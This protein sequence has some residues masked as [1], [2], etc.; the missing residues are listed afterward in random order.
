MSEPIAHL[1]EIPT[2][3]L[4][5]YI[6][7]PWCIKKC[8][9]CDFNSHTLP[10]NPPFDDYVNALL[11]DAKAQ[12]NLAIGRQITSIFVGGG[13]PSLLPINQYQRLFTELRKILPISPT[14]EITLEANPASL[15]H[16]PFAEYLSVGFNRL[17]IGVQSFDNDALSILGRVHNSEQ[18]KTAIL[19]AKNAGFLRINADIMHGLPHQTPELALHD[20]K[21]ALDLGV[22]HFSWYQLTIEPNTAFFK[23]PPPLP[24]DD[25]LAKIEQIGKE[26][27]I[28]QGFDNYEVSAWVSPND[29]P[30]QHNL[31]Y[32]QFGDY[33][34]IG[35]GAHGKITLTDMQAKSLINL[36]NY[37]KKAIYR[38]AKSRLPKDYLAYDDF[39]KFVQI[40]KIDESELIGEFMMNAL[41]LRNGVTTKTFETNTG[42]LASAIDN[43][44]IPLQHQGLMVK[45]LEVIAP[46]A[47]GFRYVNQLVQAFL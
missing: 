16:A 14:C 45:N 5:L 20:I 19:E 15:E 2:I 29:Q 41:R 1:L 31:N 36:E 11:L 44:L 35:A 34:A 21:T 9:Y 23:N 42:I 17:S 12:A 4:G 13:T 27:L 40:Q 28:A 3:G 33:L 7:I 26:F 24:D 38:F 46:T 10:D 8:P 6:H 30:C 18:A 39:P 43:E 32:W 37:P 25:T 47:L 22:T